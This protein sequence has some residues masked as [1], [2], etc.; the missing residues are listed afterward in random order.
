MK[1]LVI[2]SNTPATGNEV[3]MQRICSFFTDPTI[4]SSSS[5]TPLQN[6]VDDDLSVFPSCPPSS[7]TLSNQNIETY[8]S[9][10]SVS[11]PS[12]QGTHNDTLSVSTEADVRLPWSVQRLD[13]NKVRPYSGTIKNCVN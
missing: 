12:S 11:L 1:L 3:T 7:H 13:C 9:S 8:V 4:Y 6:T 10:D 2:S 5:S